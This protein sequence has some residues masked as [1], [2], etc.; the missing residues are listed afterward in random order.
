MEML[1]NVQAIGKIDED[2]HVEPGNAGG[3][4]RGGRSH[5]Q[6]S[7]ASTGRGQCHREWAW[8]SG[9]QSSSRHGLGSSGFKPLPERLPFVP[10]ALGLSKHS[11]C[12]SWL[13]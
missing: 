9:L 11:A 12:S 10:L 8:A 7:G 4:A 2:R 3:G 13:S 6:G 1:G 5:S